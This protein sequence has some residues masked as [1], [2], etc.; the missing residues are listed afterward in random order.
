MCFLKLAQK[1]A[2][3]CIWPH[4]Y[5]LVHRAKSHKRVF[6]NNFEQIWVGS[7]LDW[8]GQQEFGQHAKRLVR[9]FKLWPIH[10]QCTA[11]ICSIY[12]QSMAQVCS[13]PRYYQVAYNVSGEKV[14]QN[15]HWDKMSLGQNVSQPFVSYRVPGILKSKRKFLLKYKL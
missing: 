5:V 2:D 8:S 4:F 11:K 15:V 12:G 1:L 14:G 13:C 7:G 9:I 6:S 10:V 3:F